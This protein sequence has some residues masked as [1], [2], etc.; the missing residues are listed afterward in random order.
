MPRTTDVHGIEGSSSR[1]AVV[2]EIDAAA[3]RA[4]A[5]LCTGAMADGPLEIIVG[6]FSEIFWASPGAGISPYF[7]GR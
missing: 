1:S 5:A 3:K 6:I 4:R 2:V 7:A